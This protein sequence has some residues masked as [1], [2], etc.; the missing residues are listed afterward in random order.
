[1]MYDPR[2]KLSKE[3]EG[4][5]ALGINEGGS[6]AAHAASELVRDLPHDEFCP[7]EIKYYILRSAMA[8]EDFEACRIH[9]NDWSQRRS[10]PSAMVSK[11]IP[12]EHYHVLGEKFDTLDEAQQYLRS[13]GYVYG[14]L[15]EKHVYREE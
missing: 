11:F 13:R 7:C 5:L 6:F 1:M 15:T 4:W 14:G 8:R 3:N 2:A 12:G 9:I 10:R